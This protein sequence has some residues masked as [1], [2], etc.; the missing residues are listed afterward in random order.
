ME[1]CVNS[2]LLDFIFVTGT[3]QGVRIII[4]I[5]YRGKKWWGKVTKMPLGDEIFPWRIKRIKVSRLVLRIVLMFWLSKISLKIFNFF[6]TT[7]R[8]NQRI[9]HSCNLKLNRI[10]ALQKYPKQVDLLKFLRLRIAAWP[11]E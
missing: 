5:P 10:S 9:N 3:N 2:I 1:I 6:K 7:A 4:W 8:L 11:D